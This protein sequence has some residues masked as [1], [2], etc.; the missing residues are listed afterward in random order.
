MRGFLA[1]GVSLAEQQQRIGHYFQ[2]LAQVLVGYSFL[3][4]QAIANI[5]CAR[6]LIKH[7]YSLTSI[8]RDTMASRVSSLR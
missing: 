1:T 8:I 2:V 7:R 3:S 4:W 5:S 6:Q